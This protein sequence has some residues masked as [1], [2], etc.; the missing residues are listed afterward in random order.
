MSDIAIQQ[1]SFPAQAN[2]LRELFRE[3]ADSLGIDLCFQDFESELRELPGKYSAPRGGVFLAYAR[4]E[5]AG[6]VALRPIDRTSCEMKRL[7]VRSASRG[8]GV[9]RCLVEQVCAFAAGAGYQRIFLDTLPTMRAAQS[10]YASVGF[11]AVEPYVFNPV[12]GAVF[13]ARDL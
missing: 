13:L 12:E 1:A 2:I 9:G 7:Y 8:L 10:L 6:C 4:G 5:L 3:Y 11:F